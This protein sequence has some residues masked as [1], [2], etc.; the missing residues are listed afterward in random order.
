MSRKKIKT[1]IIMFIVSFASKG[2]ALIR[3]MMFANYF[4]TGDNATAF[5][6]ASNISLQFM[7]IFML[8]VIGAI[9]VPVYTRIEEEDGREGA[10][11][12]SNNFMNIIFSIGCLNIRVGF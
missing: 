5:F 9:F 11:K 8:S 4:G 12:F 7:E 3:S 1:L 2:L 6:T 10:L